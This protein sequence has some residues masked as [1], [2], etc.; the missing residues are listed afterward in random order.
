MLDAVGPDLVLTQDQARARLIRRQDFVACK[1]AFIDCKTPGSHLKENYSM[2][3]PG[4]T[5]NPDQVVN[6][7]EPHGFNIGAAAMPR[8]I[9]NNLHVHFTAEVFLVFDGEY[10]FRWGPKGSHGEW[11]GRDGDILSV[12]TWIFRGFTNV[13]PDDGM[14]FTVLGGD[15][16]G[17]IIWDADI[18]RGAA[19]YGLYLR[20]DGVLVDTSTGAPK[21][22]DSELIQPIS[23]EDA[24]SFQHWTPAR[25]AAE[26]AAPLA[27]REFAEEALLD[28]GLPGHASAIARVIGWGISEQ[29]DGF[30]RIRAP[31]GFSIE[32]L[33]I[34]PGA[35]VGPFRISEKMVL[36]NRSPGVEA[37]L[38]RGAAAV[39]LA[40]DRRDILSV[41]SGVWRSLRNTGTGPAELLV[42]CAGD[43]R[44]RIEWD[45][46]IAARARTHGRARDHDGWIAPAH[47]LP[48]TS[49]LLKV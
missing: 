36:M 4:V 18:I 2:I 12:P 11:T 1:V 16:T 23:D 26:R 44:K 27:E 17:G 30:P 33:R 5:T 10:T 28:S 3:G 22:D 40:M 13:G 35:E 32:W 7:R 19:Q 49:A 45:A 47:L 34:A 31:H 38:N 20:R 9:T 25:I 42:I 21:P 43:Q 48:S 46:D 24:R 8:G 29:R 14:V 15:D 37:T 41:P 6:L 39:K